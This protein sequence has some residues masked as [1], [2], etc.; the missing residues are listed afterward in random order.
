VK[1]GDK[2]D[3]GESQRSSQNFEHQAVSFVNLK[4]KHQLMSTIVGE[5]CMTRLT[6]QKKENYF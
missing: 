3:A 4:I 1:F 6:V 5:R 2:D